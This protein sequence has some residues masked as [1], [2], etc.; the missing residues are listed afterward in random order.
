[1]GF[2]RT[3]VMAKHH[4]LDLHKRVER[5][6]TKNLVELGRALHFEHTDV[7]VF[8]SN[9]PEMQPLVLQLQFFCALMFFAL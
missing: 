7:C 8:A 1:M 6:R 3:R 4:H 9:P 5:E 2:Q